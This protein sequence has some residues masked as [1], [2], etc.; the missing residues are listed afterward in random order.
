MNIRMIELTADELRYIVDQLEYVQVAALA[1]GLRSVNDT[2]IPDAFWLLK[3]LA[4]NRLDQVLD[5]LE[6]ATERPLS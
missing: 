1:C 4:E 6:A 5:A 3:D 2:E